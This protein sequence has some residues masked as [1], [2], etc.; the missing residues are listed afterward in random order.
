VSTDRGRAWARMLIVCGLVVILDQATKGA[1]VATMAPGE[2]TDLAL[3]V[4][5]ARVANSGI[6]FGLLDE[7]SDG[8]VLAITIASL[9]LVIGWFAVDTVRPGFWLGVGLLVGGALGN[10]A[11]RIRADAVTDFLDPPLWPAFNLADVAITAGVVVIAL[12]AL[13]PP[14][15]AKAAES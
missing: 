6:A 12:V 1:I 8:L 9:A 15:R 2:R 11:D 4:D 13:A 14:Q 10:L 5:L 3:G 7:G